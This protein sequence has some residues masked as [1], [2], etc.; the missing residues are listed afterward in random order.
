MKIDKKYLEFPQFLDNDLEGFFF[1]FPNKYP[2]VVKLYKDIAKRVYDNPKLFREIG[3]EHYK[4][5]T[6]AFSKIKGDY[7]KEY[8]KAKQAGLETELEFLTS[9][10]E[11][12][13]RMY[14]FRF[15]IINYLFPDGPLHGFYV[16]NLKNY[17]RRLANDVDLDIHDYEEKYLSIQRDLL[18]NDYADLYLQN[19]LRCVDLFK[20]LKAEPKTKKIIEKIEPLIEKQ[21]AASNKKIYQLLDPIF[22]MAEG[23]SAMA[24]KLQQ[25]MAIAI[26]QSKW[27]KT[28]MPFYTL[29]I[30][31]VE[32]AEQNKKLE[33][34]HEQGNERIKSYLD[35]AK[36]TFTKQEYEE[37]EVSYEMVR[38]FSMYK[39]VMGQIDALMLPF[40]INVV[41]LRAE[42][43]LKEMGTGYV[44]KNGGPGSFYYYLSWYLPAKLKVQIYTVDTVDFDINKI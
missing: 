4:E 25:Y 44:V 31:A 41:I 29:I 22:T 3:D 34:R 21:N 39:D 35:L 8:K 36:K 24:K 12:L 20:V 2:K 13:N 9:I 17:A 37:L 26:S 30:H 6:M 19:A 18:Q 14:C 43:I 28:K 42:I 1:V 15:W 11:R 7:D 32:F 33:E 27:R 5:L 10:D 23:K 38:N 16:E 40:W